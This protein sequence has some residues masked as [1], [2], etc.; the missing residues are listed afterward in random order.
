MSM[1]NEV[2]IT[3]P[4]IG[5]GVAA[6]ALDGYIEL[7]EQ[8][9]VEPFPNSLQV[10]VMDGVG[11]GDRAVAGAKTA[12]VALESHAHKPITLLLK[13]CHEELRGTRGIVISLA[14]VNALVQYGRGTDDALVLA[15]CTIGDLS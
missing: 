5:S 6:Q 14:L 12:V 8:H 10:A 15:A 2:T 3:S 4:L 9:L 13:R 11:H 7:G 1:G